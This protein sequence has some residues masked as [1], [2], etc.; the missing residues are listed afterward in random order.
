[1]RGITVIV[2]AGRVISSP[3]VETMARAERAIARDTID[4]ALGTGLVERVIVATDS[5]EFAESLS[6]SPVVVDVDEGEFHFG[7]R[8]REIIRRHRVERAFYFGAGSAALLSVETMSGLCQKLID[9][10]AA[11]LAN[12]FYSSDFVA[13][14]PAEAI[15]RIVPP[16]TDNNLAFSLYHQAGLPN[17]A[18]ARETG[19]QMDVDTPTDLMILSLHPGAGP[20][21]RAFLDGCDLDLEPMRR[22]VRVVANPSRQVLLSG[23]MAASSLSLVETGFACQTRAISEERGMRASGR[24]DRGEVRSILGYLLRSM[25]TDAFFESLGEMADGA[26]IDSR[27]IFAHCGLKP[28]A[29]DRF[30]SDLFRSEMITDPFVKDFTRAAARAPVPILLGG[31]SLV[32][33]D[34]WALV[35]IASRWQTEGVGDQ[36]SAHPGDG[37]R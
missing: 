7:V 9:S 13:F 34:L 29:P 16:D 12:N 10:D 27:V 4:R 25:G 3:I 17:F 19:T 31:H 26:I 11:L 24:E 22:L 28:A 32:S 1:M 23:R 30:Y 6:G 8:L 20:R 15:E 2:F 5:V 14:T 37:S 18:V 35:E 21:T 33:G 36:W